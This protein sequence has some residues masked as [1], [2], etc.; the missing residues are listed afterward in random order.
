M[1]TT[2][3]TRKGLCCTT[4]TFENQS[5]SI[6]SYHW[7]TAFFLKIFCCIDKTIQLNTTKGRL[8]LSKRSFDAWAKTQP[9]L[10]IYNPANTSDF[11]K[12]ACKEAG[13][14]TRVR[15]K[16]NEITNNNDE[17]TAKAINDWITK[18]RLSDKWNERLKDNSKKLESLPPSDEKAKLVK[19]LSTIIDGS[20][21]EEVALWF[22]SQEENYDEEDLHVET[23]KFFSMR[24]K[25]ISLLENEVNYLVLNHKLSKLS[26]I[27]EQ[28]TSNS[29]IERLKI[30]VKNFNVRDFKL[31]EK[32]YKLF[33]ELGQKVPN[34]QEVATTHRNSVPS[35]L[36]DRF[37]LVY[38]LEVEVNSLQP[39]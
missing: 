12:Y 24:H 38:F 37:N 15:V 36:V 22:K 23:P 29:H 26:A 27:L 11:V 17:E 20:I 8:Y 9:D 34:G 33:Q 18:Q 5:L 14:Q 35:Y 10:S 39:K 6:R 32:D 3:Y 30:A 13:K 7:L 4:V 28:C 21:P 1:L 19:V 31:N 2:D 16:L 25:H